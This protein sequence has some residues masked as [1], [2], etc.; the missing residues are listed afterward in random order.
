VWAFDSIAF[1]VALLYTTYLALLGASALFARRSPAGARRPRHRFGVVVPAH[2]EEA[3][4]PLLLDALARLT[5]P[6]EL[7]DIIV[8]ADNCHDRTA[9]IADARG[10]RVLERTDPERRGKGYALSWAF[11]GLLKE[12]RHDAF[13][14]LDA[15]SEPTPGLLA[16]L[17]A[18]LQD[19]A[20]AAQA[21]CAVGNGTESW[22]AA[23]MA[24]DL[25]LVHF[26]RPLG[27]KALGASAGLQGNGMCL[28][29]EVLD[30]VPWNAVSATEDQEYHLRLVRSGIRVVFVPEA[31]VPTVMQVTMRAA[32]T[33]EL[34][35]EG[36]RFRLARRHI[37][38][39]LTEAWRQPA[40]SRS[41]ICVE[42]AL[43]LTT[44]PFALLALGTALF[45]GFHGVAW[46]AGGSGAG[47]GRWLALLAGQAFYV[48]VGCALARVPA[49]TYAAL[50]VYGP[51][52]A[53]AKVWYCAQ[54]AVGVSHQWAPTP[55]E[56]R[57]RVAVS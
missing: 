22:R 13:V 7:Y 33:Q 54:V 56:R 28:T 55:R 31:Q 48:L 49:K 26:L 57:G 43:D 14:I 46:I 18:A 9:G 11:G 30:A 5:Y 51:L 16:H 2:D 12:G 32:R 52:Y 8:V 24:G 15:D 47:I 53:L 45:A 42:T 29:R 4:L 38:S 39:L 44:P 19:G 36:G 20:R 40:W 10:A 34:R 27:R 1:W 50:A 37:R 17:D 21:Y 23:L 6:K 41:W 3:M 25:A 35:W